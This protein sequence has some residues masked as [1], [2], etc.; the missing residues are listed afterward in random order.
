MASGGYIDWSCDSALADLDSDGFLDVLQSSYG[1]LS[2]GHV[3]ARIFLNDGQG[4]FE[5]FNPSGFQLTGTNIA[6]GDPAL[7]AEGTQQHQTFDAT[8]QFADVA[9]VGMSVEMGDVDGDFDVDILHS[10]KFELPRMFANRT[11]ENG[12]ALGFRDVSSA[13]SSLPTGRA[14]RASTSRSS[15]TSTTTGTSTSTA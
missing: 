8:G 5:E 15:G 11:V 12:G 3:P 9:T 2:D 10:E 6:D 7:W 1:M 4:R 14:V 13:V